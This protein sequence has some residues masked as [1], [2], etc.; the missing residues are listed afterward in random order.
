MTPT[1]IIRNCAFCSCEFKAVRPTATYCS[2]S[3]RTKANIKRRLDE[4]A[5]AD[6]E[7]ERMQEQDRLQKIV[8]AK[9][10]KREQKA[11]LQRQVQEKLDEIAKQ[12]KETKRIQDEQ[13]AAA[14]AE[15][16]HKDEEDRQILKE[17]QEADEKQRRENKVRRKNL[18]KKRND[19]DIE[20]KRNIMVGKGLFIIG[21]GALIYHGFIKPKQKST[22]VTELPKPD[23]SPNRDLSIPPLTDFN[24]TDN[25][26]DPPIKGEENT[27]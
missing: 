2:N 16:T 15:K 21:A 14:L 1:E 19:R 3:C 13:E 12:A 27:K 25:S 8:A 9:R 5:T 11:E 4:R 17:K 23:G 22:E 10:L 20:K 6:Q 26:A 18:K 24:K 7:T